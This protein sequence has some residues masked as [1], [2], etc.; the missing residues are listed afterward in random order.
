M[1]VETSVEAITRSNFQSLNGANLALL[2]SVPQIFRKSLVCAFCYFCF[3]LP[4]KQKAKT[5]PFVL[6]CFNENVCG[7]SSDANLIRADL[8]SLQICFCSYESIFRTL[9]RS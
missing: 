3:Q 4:D 7:V 1:N 9:F 6:R 5:F 2:M 8:F